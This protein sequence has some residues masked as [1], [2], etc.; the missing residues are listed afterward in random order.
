[1]EAD[2]IGDDLK[3]MAVVTKKEV[4]ISVMTDDKETVTQMEVDVIGDNKET[5]KKEVAISVM[6]D[7]KETLTQVEVDVIGDD[8]ETGGEEGA[9]VGNG[10]RTP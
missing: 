7:G 4:A 3:K 10:R 5:T 8:D 2:V 6:T 1:M 9:R